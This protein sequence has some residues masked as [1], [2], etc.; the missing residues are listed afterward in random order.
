MVS[1]PLITFA[2]VSAIVSADYT[3][4]AGITPGIA[5]LYVDPEAKLPRVGALQIYDGSLVATIPDCII[6]KIEHVVRS[7][8]R[9]NRVT[10]LDRRW[11]WREHGRISGQ[12]NRDFSFSV[13]SAAELRERGFVNA[14]ELAAM[15]L[16]EMGERRYDVSALPQKVYPYV[17]WDYA[18]PAEALAKLCD[19]YGCRP[20][21]SL[22]GNVN[23]V[24]DGV[25]RQISDFQVVDGSI[26]IDPPEA[27]DQIIIVGG[28][29]RW[30]HD[31]NLSPVALENDGSIVDLDD[32][33]YK[34][35]FDGVKT[36]DYCDFEHF[37]SVDEKYR[38]AARRSV[39][40]WY[41]ITAGFTLPG[42][43]DSVDDIKRILPILTTQIEQTKS[44]GETRDKRAIVFG[45]FVS[46]FTDAAKPFVEE[47]DR[48]INA[49]PLQLYDGSF[50]I[51]A[52]E[53]LV[54]F[55]QPVYNLKQIPGVIGKAIKAARI[56]LRTSCHLREQ[57][58]NAWV[59]HHW[60]LD[61]ENPRPGLIKYVV[62][63]DIVRTRYIDFDPR[64]ENKDNGES[65]KYH[66]SQSWLSEIAKY[67]VELSGSLTYPGFQFYDVD[68]TIRQVSF[69]LGED[70]HGVTRVSVNKE[71]PLVSPVYAERRL[72]ERVAERNRRAE[73]AKELKER[74][75]LER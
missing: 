7:T 66:A 19:R 50:S 40:K 16:E 68:G 72:F 58:S 63:D 37:T 36:W 9:V 13:S 42:R 51:D 29:D 4:A 38:E 48:N 27:P 11:R 74:L 10:I 62:D 54:M 23:I 26:E 41:R 1:K 75:G 35:T 60:E 45:V 5:T 33:S 12:Y 20:T 56:R 8:G 65:L 47:V 30:Q 15:C 44:F 43:H 55:S 69:L 53:G 46:E 67:N 71:E 59:R 32:V 64:R 21:L 57:H 22:N 52:A 14:W 17:D 18:N 3:L 2:G 24:R 39:F 25:G 34:P 49:K 73:A 70:G 6:D 31:F 28:R 61:R